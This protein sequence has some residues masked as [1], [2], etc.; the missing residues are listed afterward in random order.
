M[1]IF[2]LTQGEREREISTVERFKTV[3]PNLEADALE[4]S[5]VGTGRV[6]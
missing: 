2:S 5:A 1:K 4:C 6:Y 3:V